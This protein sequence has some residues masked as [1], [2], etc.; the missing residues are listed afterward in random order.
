M[1]MGE[2]ITPGNGA[3]SSQ[4]KAEF[5]KQYIEISLKDLH[6]HR[7]ENRLRASIV[8]LITIICAGVVTIL[9]GLQIPKYEVYFKGTA[10]ILGAIVTMINALEPF[11]NFRTLWIDH[12]E[13]IARMY[14]LKNDVDFY[15]TG[16]TPETIEI[17]RLEAFLDR[18][19]TIWNALNEN[20]IKHRRQDGNQ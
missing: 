14:R 20:Y 3:D 19:K 2:E 17:K 6:R 13:A 10:L 9:L 8:K 11:F 15:L 16:M 1:T 7:K 18:Y 4:Q 12:E 5:L